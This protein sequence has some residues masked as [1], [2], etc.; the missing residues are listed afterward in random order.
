MIL[1]KM[2]GKKIM[3]FFSETI[4]NINKDDLFSYEEIQ[5]FF[6]VKKSSNIKTDIRIKNEVNFSILL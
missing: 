4:E 5:K 1:M 3:N 6:Q 2:S